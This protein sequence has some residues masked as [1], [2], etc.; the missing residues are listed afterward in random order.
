MFKQSIKYMLQYG[1]I[2]IVKQLCHCLLKL[3]NSLD[4]GDFTQ[5]ILY[6]GFST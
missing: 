4:F 6:F 3:P 2:N 5:I 1:K